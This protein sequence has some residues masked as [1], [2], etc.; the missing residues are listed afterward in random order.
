[1]KKGFELDS[2]RRKS[3]SNR[4][5]VYDLR[6]HEISLQSIPHEILLTLKAYRGEFNEASLTSFPMVIF[7]N[8]GVVR[9]LLAVPW[10]KDTV[11]ATGKNLVIL[12]PTK[13]AKFPRETAKHG[14]E[15]THQL[16]N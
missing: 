4:S 1:M 12:D 8:P 5:Q 15:R 2:E 16:S 7:F 10:F 6:L 9:E 11:I 3:L 13:A 14:G